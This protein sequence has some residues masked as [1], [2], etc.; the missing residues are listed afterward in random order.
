MSLLFLQK[1]DVGGNVKDGSEVPGSEQLNLSIDAVR[2]GSLT[3]RDV[4][5]KLDV[6]RVAYGAGARAVTDFLTSLL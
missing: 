1:A 5:G 2:R 3:P 6:L 4:T